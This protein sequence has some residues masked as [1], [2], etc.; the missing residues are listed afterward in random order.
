MSDSNEA[1]KLQ[2]YGATNDAGDFAVAT[3][4]GVCLGE[5]RALVETF[6]CCQP[7]GS[8]ASTMHRI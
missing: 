7:C 5:D 1:T 6:Y 4:G 8:L 2:S 3:Y